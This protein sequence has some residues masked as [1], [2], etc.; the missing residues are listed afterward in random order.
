MSLTVI[1]E[2]NT[3]Y[4]D[5]Y[6]G[7]WTMHLTNKTLRFICQNIKR[8]VPDVI[9]EKDINL[10]SNEK[11][12]L[13]SLNIGLYNFYYTCVVL[14]LRAHK[15]VPDATVILDT[16]G[17]ITELDTTYFKFLLKLL[18]DLNIKYEVLD[19][20][21]A[22]NI[23]V[24]D[25]YILSRQ[26]I[27]HEDVEYFYN[28]LQKYIKNKDVKPFR[29]AY[30]AR[31]YIHER[32]F[33]MMKPGLPFSD[34]NRILNEKELEEYLSS[35]GFEIVYPE[36]FETFIDQI[37]YFNE[38]HTVI[39]LTSSGITNSIFMKPGGTLI[40]LVTP[41]VMALGDPFGKEQIHGHESI[42]HIYH[43]MTYNKRHNYV[44]IPNFDRDVSTIKNTVS[45]NKNIL[46]FFTKES[47]E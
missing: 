11:K 12:I 35:C 36:D 17:I 8:G 2:T 39:S 38:V 25:F 23:Y 20:S 7:S 47:D 44:G 13:V 27:S 21:D 33:P 16:S 9:N 10:I 45:L 14:L 5:H 3:N 24:N 15:I 34:D 29:K 31:K 22:N 30:I 6:E 1:K 26:E 18:D 32:V 46:S 37:N 41:L 4:L 28:V 40:E 19:T 42:H 43:A